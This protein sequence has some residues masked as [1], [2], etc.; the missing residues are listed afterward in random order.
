MSKLSDVDPA[1]LRSRLDDAESPKA[2][3]RLIVALAYLD[4]VPVDDISDR[5]GF[6]RSTIYSW[7][8]RF[9][10]RGVDGALA[11]DPRPGRPRDLPDDDF[12]AL[13]SAVTNPPRE[14]G[15]DAEEWTPELLV[16]YVRESFGVSYSPG[17]ARRLLREL[18]A[19]ERR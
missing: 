2:A 1:K 9:E 3:K 10:Q 11:D 7:L 18:P 12:E 13:A 8:D 6:P 14:V 4:G 19:R 16:R 5:Y 15:F 17:H